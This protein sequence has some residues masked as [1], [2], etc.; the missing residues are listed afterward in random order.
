MSKFNQQDLGKTIKEQRINKGFTQQQ[1]AEM[2]N[3]SESLISKWESGTCGVDVEYL[4]SLGALFGMTIDEMFHYQDEVRAEEE[5]QRQE[6][7]QELMKKRERILNSH[8]V[9]IWDKSKKYEDVFEANSFTNSE[10]KDFTLTIYQDENPDITEYAGIL[11]FGGSRYFA[12]RDGKEEALPKYNEQKC[13]CAIVF[14]FSHPISAIRC[15]FDEEGMDDIMISI[16]Y[17]LSDRETYEKKQAEQKREMLVERMNVEYVVQEEGLVSLAFS[18]ANEDF[19]YAEIEIYRGSGS[20]RPG[21]HP[22]SVCW[23]RSPEVGGC[24]F[25]SYELL[26]SI[27]LPNGEK[28][29]SSDPLRVIFFAGAI[30]VK[31]YDKDARLIVASY[32]PNGD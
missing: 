24:V 22:A 15:T 16:V 26:K 1:L 19:A 2:L 11:D 20:R 9:R 14:D 7:E 32:L 4:S 12:V 23:S 13:S 21:I 3:V 31:Q 28:I 5:R 17:R 27:R 18:A 30:V 29:W 6:R 8:Y 10:Y 25:E